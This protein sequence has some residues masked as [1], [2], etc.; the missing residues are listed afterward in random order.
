[1]ATQAQSDHGP[2]NQ[3]IPK[4]NN[5]FTVS[6]EAF[7]RIATAVQG[8]LERLHATTMSLSDAHK[9]LCRGTGVSPEVVALSLARK[10]EDEAYISKIPH[11]AMIILRV[12]V[13]D[14][15][16]K[17][18]ERWRLTQSEIKAGRIAP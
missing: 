16:S 10:A 18:A 13:G 11:D 3:L 12:L 14:D 15:P 6:P 9:E 1:M 2:V 17:I 5:L 4:L 7:D 8:E